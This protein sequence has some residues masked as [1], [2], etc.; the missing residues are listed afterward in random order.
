MLA[1]GEPV[2]VADLDRQRE[3]GQ[4][5]D[6]AQTRQPPRHRGEL[7]VGGQRGDLLVQPGTPGG[8]QH[9]R[10]VG[11]LERRLRRHASRTAAAAATGRAARSTPCRRSRRSRAAAT[12]STPGAGPA[13]DPPAPPPA[14]GPDHARPPRPASGPAPTRSHPT[15]ATAPDASHL[16]RRSSPDHQPGA[17]ASTTPPPR[18]AT[19]PPQRADQ[20][21]PGR[22]RLIDHRARTR[23][24]A[25]PLH[26]LL[27][28]RRQPRL[29]H[30]ARRP[31]IAAAVT[32]R[33]CTSSPTLLRSPNTGASSH[34]SD[35]PSTEPRS[36]THEIA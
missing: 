6:A 21:E 36:V 16:G 30:L 3:P 15:A 13:S 4:R 24:L 33:A 32:D 12:A 34:M 18:T 31:S 9:H 23:Q 5:R 14:P 19:P 28:C 17:A 29:E 26:D 1:A 8:G 10:L 2:P 11:V 22:A 27:M 7:A 20:T 35:R 25:D